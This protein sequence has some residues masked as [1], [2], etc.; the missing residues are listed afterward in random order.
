[1]DQE[2]R[3]SM[4]PL[5]ESAQLS[6]TG[7]VSRRIFALGLTLALACMGLA[8]PAA[9][10]ASQRL[11]T[12]SIFYDFRPVEQYVLEVSGISSP[13]A[14]ILVAERLPAFLIMAPELDSA[15]ILMPRNGTTQS[16]PIASV[17]K[18]SDGSFALLRDVTL[19]NEG[20]FQ[21]AGK[22]VSFSVGGRPVVLKEKPY[23]LGLQQVSAMEAYSSGYRQ[24]ERE[25]SPYS[26][27]L[28][29]LRSF[30]RDVRVRVFFGTWCAY[31]SIYVPRMMQV[32][33]ELSDSTIQ[34][35][36]YGLPS[37]ATQDPIV[38][39]LKID[40]VPTGVIYVDGV[41]VARIRGN[42]WQSPETALKVLLEDHR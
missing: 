32:A 28:E 16:L 8:G 23:L 38:N 10:F 13:G 15:V 4:R 21:V 14:Q 22:D 11:P 40:G 27:V 2:A 3:I 1:M 18:Q 37:P 26:A 24:R 31:C 9:A 20:R 19:A 5:K 12:H 42:M 7:P 39:E 36:F 33:R 35:E 34:V 25:Y 41:E 6:L 29:E 17:A 30:P